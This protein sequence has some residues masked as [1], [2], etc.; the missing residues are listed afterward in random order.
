MNKRYLDHLQS[1][2]QDSE[3]D[4]WEDKCT[5]QESRSIPPTSQ[6]SVVSLPPA[7]QK[8]PSTRLRNGGHS[9]DRKH[10]SKTDTDRSDQST[11]PRPR[12]RKPAQL[13]LHTSSPHLD[14]P[15]S[16]SDNTGLGAKHATLR[17]NRPGPATAKIIKSAKKHKRHLILANALSSSE[18]SD[19]G[20]SNDLAVLAS[21]QQSL[22][23][24]SSRQSER[25]PTPPPLSSQVVS[26]R[27]AA[28]KPVVYAESDT[29]SPPRPR[30]RS[31]L[32]RTKCIDNDACVEEC[33]E[34]ER[35]LKI[36]KAAG[37][38]Y[39]GIDMDVAKM[40]ALPL[41][42]AHDPAMT[43]DTSTFLSRSNPLGSSFISSEPPSGSIKC[44]VGQFCTALL[45]LPLSPRLASLKETFD[46][47]QALYKKGKVDR[48]ALQRT[49][50]RFCSYH[51]A[52]ENI[53]PE[54]ITKGYPMDIDF[55]TVPERLEA[56][57]AW[58][59]DVIEGTVYSA[60][61]DSLKTKLGSLGKKQG[62]EERMHH[63]DRAQCGYYGLTG[64]NLI[65]TFLISRYKTPASPLTPARASPLSVVDYIQLILVPE[66]SLL[67]IAQDRGWDLRR[68]KGY[69]QA[70]QVWTDSSAFGDVVYDD[71]RC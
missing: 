57:V 53:I 24:H 6:S 8:I 37:K 55:A 52:E 46:R 42:F 40:S 44:P 29:S 34:K 35:K 63:M 51:K 15:L 60:F 61:R 28:K 33:R 67:L 27:E 36:L 9:S 1:V 14:L 50:D 71:I 43:F 47:S 22:L 23:A 59:Q 10:G 19:A 25:A 16:P 45:P 38:S 11:T 26:Q 64:S 13:A 4:D 58:F 20:V 17:E 70:V 5:S 62:V 68:E 7:K 49:R 18:S 21:K 69:S 65:F 48:Q 66:A 2:L 41:K 30:R 31:S 54:G 12:S 32:K 3:S 39:L 56:H